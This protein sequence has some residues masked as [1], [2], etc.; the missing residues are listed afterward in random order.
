MYVKLRI[1]V[2]RRNNRKRFQFVVNIRRK[3]VTSNDIVL[4]DEF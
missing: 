1:R 3:G 2:E 4:P